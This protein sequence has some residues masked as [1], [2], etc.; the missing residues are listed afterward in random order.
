M[1]LVDSACWLYESYGSQAVRLG[2]SSL[3]LWGLLPAVPGAG[4]LADRIGNARNLKLSDD[5]ACWSFLGVKQQFARGGGEDL[6]TSGLVPLWR[7]A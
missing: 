7:A 1:T 5:L 3:D 2:W 6:V 4:G